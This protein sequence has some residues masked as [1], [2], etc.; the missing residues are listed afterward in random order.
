[1]KKKLLAKKSP[2]TTLKD[3]AVNEMSAA[4]PSM[5]DG[6]SES[7]ASTRR[8]SAGTIE[9]TDRFTNIEN[10]LTPFKNS[11][12]VGSSNSGVDVKDAVELCQ[13]AYYN[14]SVFRNVIDLMTEFS[15]S[16]VHF[17]NGTVK[18]RDFFEA[19]MRKINI[20]DLQ[21]KF[22]REYYRSGNVFLYRY[23]SRL[24]EADI[25]KITQ[26]FGATKA[27]AAKVSLPT[28]FVVL[29]PADI[30][31]EGTINFGTACYLKILNNYELQR[32]KNPLTDEDTELLES[33]PADA[34]QKIKEK[35]AIE[36][37][38]PLQ[39]ENTVAVFYKKQDYEPFAVPMGYPVLEDINA[40]C[41]MKRIDMAIARTMQQVLLLVTAGNEPDKHGINPNNLTV[42]QKLFE[43]QSVGRVLVADYTTKAEF[44]IPQIADLLD[45]KKYEVI[46]RDI[47]IGLNNIFAGGEK[48]ANQTAKMEVFIARLKQAR[49][50][51]INNFL[52]PEIKKISK[53]LGFKNF[54]IPVFE[55]IDLKDDGVYAKI[56][57]HLAEIGVLTPEEAMKAIE[58]NRLP[59]AESSLE[60]QRLF[61]TYKD[62]GL[63]EPLVGG[64]A[65]GEGAGRPGGTPSPK[66]TNTVSPIG[67]S[68]ESYSCVKLRKTVIAAQVLEE[69]VA[70]A[71]KKL[72]KLKEIDAASSNAFIVE[73]IFKT[74][75]ANEE[76]DKWM[77]SIDVYLNDPID[78][79]AKRVGEVNSIAAKHDVDFYMASLLL[80]SKKT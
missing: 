10:G 23:S 68:M 70:K 27:V 75:I 9:R 79:N 21:D 52:F 61:K 80:A 2:K 43:N 49:E 6:Y 3:K 71:Y 78:K 15:V 36:V 58:T 5:L 53:D 46:E 73:Q 34:Q 56:Y 1:M 64:P 32:L 11:G 16:R 18:S 31:V 28:R 20:W 65:A 22:F 48:F 38:L 54:P 12:R 57:M 33:L 44:V 7:F 40:K 29:N 76:P 51:F 13:K 72:H 41:E 50:A 19:Y 63:Y 35:K 17:K 30:R 42:L 77:E 26:V 45:P 37:L 66:T 67:G 59:D 69:A 25:R 39:P 60:A 62:E 8:N 47:N 14:F 74:I 55:E 24:N 4:A